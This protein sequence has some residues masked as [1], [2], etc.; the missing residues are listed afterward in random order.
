MEIDFDGMTS[1]R[2]PCRSRPENYVGLVAAGKDGP[3]SARQGA[4]RSHADGDSPPPLDVMRFDLEKRKTE[5]LVSGVTDVQRRGRTA[6]RCSTGRA[7]TGS[8]PAPTRPPRPGE[9][10]LKLDGAEVCVDPRAEWRQMYRE[11][12]RIQRDFLYDP[13]FH[14]LDLKAAETSTSR[15]WTGSAAA[16]T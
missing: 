10:A 15:S 11:T 1:A 14:G 8:S 13:G 4:A 7:T 16:P 6:R 12:W 2:S 3:S 5:N 9:G